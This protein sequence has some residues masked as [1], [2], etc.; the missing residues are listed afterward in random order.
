[1]TPS[2]VSA[3]IAPVITHNDPVSSTPGS[4]NWTLTGSNPDRS[5]LCPKCLGRY[6]TEF[7]VC[8]K[9]ATPLENAPE[10]SDPLLGAILGNTYQ[11][12]RALGEGGM[13]K[14]YEAGHLRLGA[15]RFAVKVLHAEY[16]RH[17]DVLSR[18]QREAEAAASIAHTH[19]LEVFDVSRTDDGRPYIVGEFLDGEDFHEYLEKVGKLDVANA[20]AITR[21]L[22]G[23]LKAAHDAGI[24]H[25]DLK[26]ENVYVVTDR[27][28][29]GR[30][31]AP[32][33]KILDFGI[34]KVAGKETNLT[35]TGMIM[36][37]PNYMAP[38]Q[39]RGEKVDHRVDVYA[40][41]AILYRMLTGKRAFEGTDPGA[42]ITAVLSEEPKRPRSIEPSIPEAIE[43]I[44][45]KAM[46]KDKSERYQNME[47][48]D[49][50]LAVFDLAGGMSIPPP[51]GAGVTVTTTAAKSDEHARTFIGD[52]SPAPAAAAVIERR[53]AE[54]EQLE[55]K[56]REAKLARPTI[57][58][59]TPVAAAWIFIM[60]VTAAAGVIR[61][62]KGKEAEVSDT[63]LG[64]M[65]LFSGIAFIT[66]FIVWIV[67][68]VKNVWRNSVRAVELAADM[69]RFLAGSL[70]GYGVAAVTVRIAYT[71]I[72]RDTKMV[73]AGW[74]DPVFLLFA[75]FGGA[76]GAG[77]G[78]LVRLRRRLLNA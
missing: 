19:V 57:V 28:L 56:G 42:V 54:R 61:A 44:V 18:F 14:V 60:V 6:P 35:R 63:E 11:I 51:P 15:R 34:S 33:V 4:G 75:A 77:I 66:P 5:R 62:Y 9:D 49:R 74:W 52:N 43:M 38:E 27:Q 76:F 2:V 48:F 59:L 58:L 22:C 78:P 10:E 17:S 71:V 7:N 68:L 31:G 3:P 12:K 13:G 69:R 53:A 47:E 21:Q 39:A 32:F 64:L 67:H 65:I 37:T 36:G 29:V 40:L 24:V 16:A 41:G 20:V 8:P 50:D 70:I 1:M 46:A 30:K 26:P 73:L 25:R 72:F 45:Q 23:A 55:M